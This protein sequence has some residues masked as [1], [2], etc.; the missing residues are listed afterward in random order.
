MAT[1]P[2][3]SCGKALRFRKD[4]QAG[5]RLTCPT[6]GTALEVLGTAPLELDWSFEAPIQEQV[7]GAV[8]DAE[9]GD[10]LAQYET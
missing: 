9:T 2:C 10:G 7:S 5:S 1:V 4:P 6:C 8:E 3:P